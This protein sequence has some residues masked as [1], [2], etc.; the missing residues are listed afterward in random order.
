MLQGICQ[1]APAR[2]AP[3]PD[4]NAQHAPYLRRI[5][6]DRRSFQDPMAKRPRAPAPHGMRGGKWPGWSQG[7]LI[8]A[9]IYGLST[10]SLASATGT[11]PLHLRDRLRD[12]CAHDPWPRPHQRPGPQPRLPRDDLRP[13]PQASPWAAGPRTQGLPASNFGGL[14]L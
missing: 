4:R 7:E 6:H 9:L 5:E 1:R 13:A 11:S 12:G 10:T 3:V 14:G 8:C 2:V